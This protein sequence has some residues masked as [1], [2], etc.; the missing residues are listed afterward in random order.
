M[1]KNRLAKNEKKI[2]SWAEKNFFEAYRLYDRDIPEFQYIVDRY[3]DHFVIY[4]KTDPVKDAKKNFLPEVIESIQSLFLIDSDKIIIKKRERK[5]GLNQ[6]ERL[7]QT[8]RRMQIRE[9]KAQFHVNLYDYLDT[10]LFLD[11][12]P[13]RQEM[14]KI[15][16]TQATMLNLFCYTASMSVA[17][18]LSGVSTVNVDMS[19][20]YL[21]WA[22]DNFSLN[23]I[24]LQT[25]DFI[26][27][28]ALDFLENPP[29]DDH[30]DLIFLDPP[31]FSNSKRMVQ[32]FEVERDQEL[33]V[34]QAMKLLKPGGKLYFSNNKRKFR[35]EPKLET[36]YKIKNITERTIPMDFHDQK[37][38]QCYEIST[39]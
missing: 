22:R 20:T 31:T 38:H 39:L 37:I 10:G 26:Q 34:S 5:E 15:K 28:D 6:Y 16:A 25:H 18:A 17:A 4:D 8:E 14:G 33:I 9:G 36:L 35:L 23:E 29:F 24:E 7:D 3:K 1:F 12:R 11:H 13:L 21:A 19:K 30:Y 27:N 32:N 2:K